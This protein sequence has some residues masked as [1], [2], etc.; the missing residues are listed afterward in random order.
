MA[1]SMNFSVYDV[2]IFIKHS[3]QCCFRQTK[4]LIFISTPGFRVKQLQLQLQ[5][6]KMEDISIETDAI[7]ANWYLVAIIGSFVILTYL[8]Y[9]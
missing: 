2:S 7:K 4:L 1:S 3:Q 5:I 9:I 8:A 6:I